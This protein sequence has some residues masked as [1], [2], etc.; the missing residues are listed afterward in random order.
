MK[1]HAEKRRVLGTK[2]WIWK[3]RKILQNASDF[4]LE[5]LDHAHHWL[6]WPCMGGW[7]RPMH[8]D[9]L[10]ILDN[11]WQSVQR[12]PENLQTNMIFWHVLIWAEMHKGIFLWISHKIFVGQ[13]FRAWTDS[14]KH[15]RLSLPFRFPMMVK[16][17]FDICKIFR[18]PGLESQCDWSTA[19]QVFIDLRPRVKL[20]LRPSMELTRGVHVFEN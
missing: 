2:I 5:L 8:S 11:G 1:V 18:M 20:L 14:T 10:Q 6:W 13:V 3:A 7:A 12:I 16:Q 4:F 9:L 17:W 15:N 19:V